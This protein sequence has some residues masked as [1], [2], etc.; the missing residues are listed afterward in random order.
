M[1]PSS[2]TN[3]VQAFMNLVT[4]SFKSLC[5]CLQ[6]KEKLEKLEKNDLE[7]YFNLILI[8]SFVW[9]VGGNLYDGAP[10][11]SRAKYSQFIKSKILKIYT[12]FPFEGDVYDYFID[13]EAKEFKNWNDVVPNFVFDSK[14]PFFNIIVPTADTQKFGFII[15]K[16]VSSGFNVLTTGETGVGKSIIMNEFLMKVNPESF[17]WANLNFSA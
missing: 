8:F 15:N 7:L 9:S 5:D 4:V 10:F 6:G 17:V 12:S 13:F 16:L 1:I 2:D 11:N 14:V 3:L